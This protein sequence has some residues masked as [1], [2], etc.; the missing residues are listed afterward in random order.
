MSFQKQKLRERLVDVE[1][2]IAKEKLKILSLH[3]QVASR[4]KQKEETASHKFQWQNI[5]Q[6]G[7]EQAE[8]E[9]V[10]REA[11]MAKLINETKFLRLD[12]DG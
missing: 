7:L 3:E 8:C 10:I 2:E 12:I 9:I 11:V 6:L 1:Y 5:Y 4:L